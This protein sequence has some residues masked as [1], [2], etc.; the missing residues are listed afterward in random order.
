MSGTLFQLSLRGFPIALAIASC[1][2]PTA[3]TDPVPVAGTFVTEVRSPTRNL[4]LSAFDPEIVAVADAG[5][6][7]ITGFIPFDLCR[8]TLS[9]EFSRVGQD[10]VV[11]LNNPRRPDADSRVCLQWDAETRYRATLTGLVGGEYRVIVIQNPAR[12]LVNGQLIARVD[13]VVVGA[14]TIASTP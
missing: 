6:L 4:G 5:G 9:G 12:R 2:S 11:S 14:V 10:L 7:E 8:Q 3:A 1:S 13:T